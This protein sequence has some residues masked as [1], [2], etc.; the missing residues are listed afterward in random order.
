MNASYRQAKNFHMLIITLWGTEYFLHFK[1]LSRNL[2]W[3]VYSH[4]DINGRGGIQTKA[5]DLNFSALG[6]GFLEDNFSFRAGSWMASG[7]FKCITFLM[8]FQFS[9]VA[10]SCPDP[11][12]PMDCSTPGLPVHHWLPELA[13][14]HVHWVGDAIQPSHPLSAPSPP[15]F[16]LSQHQGLFKWVN[17]SHEVAKVLDF[18]LQHQSLQWTP[19]TD[20]L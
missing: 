11:L 14:T 17:S 19:R 2:P 1:Q 4:P 16:N 6:T 15:A 20:L 18:Q 9:S 8:H 10:Q 3:S 13:Q 5:V 12:H 7:W